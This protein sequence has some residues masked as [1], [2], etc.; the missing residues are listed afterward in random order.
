MRTNMAHFYLTLPSNSSMRY[1]SNNTVTHFITHL[2]NTISLSGDWEVG[3]I[4]ICYPHSWNNIEKEECEFTY[5]QVPKMHADGFLWP[6]FRKTVQ[7]P[8]GYYESIADIVQI[9]N[10]NILEAALKYSLTRYPKFKY[11]P[12][13]KILKGDINLG[14]SI[15]FSTPL[16]FILG[17]HEP[18]NPIR[19]VN[20]GKYQHEEHWETFNK[21]WDEVPN[22]DWESEYIGD[23]NRGFSYIYVYCNLLEHTLVGDTKAPLLRIVNIDGKSGDTAHSIYDNVLYVPLHQKSFDSIEID[24]RNDS[25]HSIPFQYG[26]SFV[27]LHFRKR[28]ILQ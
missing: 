28:K 3:L 17:I 2:P 8:C 4:E 1:S 18:E 7:I 15:E 23:I 22:L 11:D 21:V 10:E 19:N 20:Y 6:S 16:A 26:K 25:G 14:A 27:T 13:T 9:I 5:S 24:M 12:I